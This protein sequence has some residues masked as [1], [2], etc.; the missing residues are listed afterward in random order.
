MQ[1][2]FKNFM[3]NDEETAMKIL[4]IEMIQ[5]FTFIYCIYVVT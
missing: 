1:F 3:S 2:S 5:V 4:V